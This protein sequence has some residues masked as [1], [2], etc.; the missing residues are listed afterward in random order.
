MRACLLA[1][2]LQAAAAAAVP[3]SSESGTLAPTHA[4]RVHTRACSPPGHL[5]RVDRRD[6]EARVG[7]ARA[8]LGL[9]VL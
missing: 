2:G 1:L 8:G 6:H 7:R 4:Q 3:G 5:A 9:R